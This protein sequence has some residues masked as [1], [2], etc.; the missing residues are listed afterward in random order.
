MELIQCGRLLWMHQ[1]A[2]KWPVM[3][4]IIP[5]GKQGKYCNPAQNQFR[6]HPLDYLEGLENHN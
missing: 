4:F 3:Y 5:D 2:R 1:T 6:Q